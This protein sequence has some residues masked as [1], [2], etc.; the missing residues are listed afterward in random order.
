MRAWR[1]HR[2]GA[3][4]EA[5]RLEETPAPE[6]GPGRVRIRVGA[7]AL[8]L[9]DDRL[10][11]GVYHLK[12]PLP[13]VPGLEV[14]GVI[15]AVGEGAEASLGERV[16]AVTDLPHGGLAEAA[17]AF[18][19]NIYRVPDGMDDAR[20]AGTLIPYQ[21]GWFALHRRGA[22]R[23]GETLLVHAGAGGVGTA[24]I[25]LGVAAGARVLATAGGPEKT[26]LCRELGA[27][28][29]IDYRSEDFVERVLEAT[30]GRGADVI[31]DPVGGEVFH[32]S[33]KCIANEGR[34]LVVGFASGELAEAPTNLILYRN[35]SV[36]G[37]YMGAYAG[38]DALRLKR[39]VHEKLCELYAAGR[40]DPVVRRVAFE[41]VPRAITD[42]AE[43]RTVGKVV[44]LP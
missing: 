9:P 15:E 42:L 11:R 3:P 6:P 40:F 35:Y 34:L 26:A 30:A 36:V 4:A 24:A 1:V 43:R 27:E 32:R 39:E 17:L 21:T 29:A 31:Y 37:V 41:D 19:T 38:A 5:L 28:V 8:N 25:Q 16:M 13:F 12:P 44:A 2:H 7:A 10:C 33:R 22:L 23:P 20:A 18:A 14:A